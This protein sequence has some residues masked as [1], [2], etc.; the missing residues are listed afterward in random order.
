MSKPKVEYQSINLNKPENLV[1]E[2]LINPEE[3]FFIAIRRDDGT[4]SWDMTFGKKLLKHIPA[5]YYFVHVLIERQH[6]DIDALRCR[7]AKDFVEMFSRDI[8][9]VKS[10]NYFRFIWGILRRLGVIDY[11]DDMKPNKY[12][13]SAKA[14]YFKFTPD[15]SESRIMQHQILIKKVFADKLNKKWNMNQEKHEIDISI[16][17]NNKH[18][19]H[20]YKALRIMNFDS[21]SAITHTKELLNEQ[22]I[23]TKKYNTCMSSINNIINGRIKVT[24]SRVCG[25]FYSPVTQLPKELRQFIKDNEGK[26]LVE[27]DFGSFNAFAV[28]KIL[29][30]VNP[31]YKANADK[32]SFR[33]EFQ[34][35]K[36]ILSSGDFYNDFKEVFLP[37]EELSRDEIKEIVLRKWFN[38]R[39]NSR[40][41]YRKLLLKRLPKISE[42]IDSLKIA[43]YE[44]FSNITMKMESELV[45][46]IIYKK[47]IELYP[48]AI[49]YTIFDSFLIERKYA[50]QLH[51]MMLEEGSRYFN[52]NCIVKE[53]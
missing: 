8:E 52:L 40:N 27:L 39:L 22:V 53:K 7:F 31:E 3:E 34:L 9:P 33:N 37:Q 14:Y 10:K 36:D 42:I 15:Y 32:Y 47:F 23:D 20:Q 12:K 21:Q 38:G 29:N 6:S 45:N 43:K 1:L 11:Q 50:T 13:K 16:V 41:K 51:S 46:D 49:M 2:E 17:T 35:Y 26:S 5:M 24:H 4:N 48:D 44:N 28:Y 18:L 25:R 19:A 30:G